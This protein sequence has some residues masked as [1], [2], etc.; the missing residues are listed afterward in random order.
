MYFEDIIEIREIANV[1]GLVQRMFIGKLIKKGKREYSIKLFN[2]LKYY[3]K[4]K[5]KKN[6]NFLILIE[7]GRAS[8][9]ER[10]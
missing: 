1:L 8:C 6:P 4:Q 10:V 3:L 7:I 5:T 2:S 9:R